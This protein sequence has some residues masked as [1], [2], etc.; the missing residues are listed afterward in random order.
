MLLKSVPAPSWSDGVLSQQQQFPFQEADPSTLRSL[1]VLLT[2]AVTKFYLENPAKC[3][4]D[5]TSSGVGDSS[6][7][8]ISILPS[9]TLSALP[10]CYR[11]LEA[12]SAQGVQL[13]IVGHPRYPSD[14]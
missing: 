11:L 10:R 6:H 4:V 13:R 9:A 3:Y 2:P 12:T 7:E 5:P 8:G 1:L 14:L